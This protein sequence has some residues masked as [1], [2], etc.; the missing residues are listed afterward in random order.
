MRQVCNDNEEGSTASDFS[1]SWCGSC[2]GSSFDQKTVHGRM[3]PYMEGHFCLGCRQL[4]F[5][6]SPQVC[7]G[8]CAVTVTFRW[9][10]TTWFPSMS[11]TKL[12]CKCCGST[13]ARVPPQEVH[14]SCAFFSA[15]RT[16]V[17]PNPATSP[18]SGS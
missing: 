6:R 1:V 2:G 9:N 14:R 18:S 16:Q 8:G 3:K 11:R 15:I 10:F 7:L 5:K 4:E 13:D 12:S 17:E